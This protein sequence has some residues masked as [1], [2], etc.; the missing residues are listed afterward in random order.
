[1]ITTTQLPEVLTQLGATAVNARQ[2]RKR[3][4]SSTNV[5]FE[6]DGRRGVAVAASRKVDAAVTRAPINAF[7]DL[8]D[9]HLRSA[10]DRLSRDDVWL[11][12]AER[13]DD[14]E[15]EV[16]FRTLAR[17]LRGL[18][19]H[20]RVITGGESG[21]W[22]LQ[23]LPDD[24]LPWND[25]DHYRYS[26]WPGLLAAVPEEP[27]AL[28]TDL[29][30]ATGR[31]EYRAYPMLSS[32]GRD[33]SIRFEGLQV[34]V[35]MATKGWFDVGRVH[36][37]GRTS[38][39]RKRWVGVAG[40]E[41]IEV[42]ASNVNQVATILQKFAAAESAMG[43]QDEHALESRILR[44]AVSLTS[45]T[46]DAPLELIRPHPVV[47][48]GSQFPTRWG[49]RNGAARYLDGILRDGRTPWA[50]EMKVA[51]GSGEQYY[52]HAVHQAVL[53][54]DFIRGATPLAGW[55]DRFD[56]DQAV[57][58]AAVVVPVIEDPEAEGR[59]RALAARFGVHLI[60]VPVAAALRP[61]P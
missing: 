33:W 28:V 57:C 4:I 48:W 43:G 24:L 11:W 15:T 10:D 19:V 3:S 51:G 14:L 47:N 2:D 29:V 37:D 22:A 30:K 1:M 40:A 18:R 13:P 27:P 35:V 59:L 36:G 52:R 34:G 44:G 61:Q 49:V 26:R 16:A 39:H 31:C 45:P 17:N 38:H 23:E 42:G 7:T 25:L 32:G 46:A 21:P 56:L 8:V 9:L 60:V 20:I 50:L 12:F 54:R 41:R 53:Y 6:K 55:F 5:R 58:E